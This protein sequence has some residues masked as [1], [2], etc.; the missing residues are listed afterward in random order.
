MSFIWEG[1]TDIKNDWPQTTSPQG[2]EFSLPPRRY[3]LHLQKDNA[4]PHLSDQQV[5]QILSVAES[6]H[7]L[8]YAPE[9]LATL[10]SHLQILHQSAK[11]NSIWISLTNTS[12][13]KTRPDLFQKI[14]QIAYQYKPVK[15]FVQTMTQ[16]SPPSVFKTPN[17]QQVL[18]VLLSTLDSIQDLLISFQI[19]PWNLPTP[20]NNTNSHTT[21]YS[22]SFSTFIIH[23][24]NFNNTSWKS[25]SISGKCSTTPHFYAFDHGDH[26]HIV[27]PSK[28]HSN[29]NR[30][31]NRILKYLQGS[32]AGTAEAYTTVQLVKYIRK[33][34]YYLIRYGLRK[35][36][37]F[38]S[39]LIYFHHSLI[40]WM[41]LTQY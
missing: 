36:Y 35:F 22:E 25:H 13:R 15:M 34:I 12:S 7:Q 38:G 29:T 21:E 37:K 24:S 9:P 14:L 4:E 1:Q 33:F 17:L 3:I 26:I 18:T 39:K 2:K 23:N 5:N 11:E 16:A 20:L 8:R 6:I 27:F 28:N 41:N 30:S 40:P 19:H 31:I 10:T 32:A